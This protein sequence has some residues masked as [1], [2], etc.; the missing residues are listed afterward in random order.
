MK[1]VIIAAGMG[2]RLHSTGNT[3]PKILLKIHDQPVLYHLLGNCVQTG[4]S[5]CV[6]VTGTKKEKFSLTWQ[7]LT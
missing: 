1:L 3:L 4:I 7:R 6:I 2:T 5:S